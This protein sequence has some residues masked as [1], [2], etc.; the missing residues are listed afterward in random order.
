MLDLWPSKH[1]ESEN[2]KSENFS[3]S[4]MPE[5]WPSEH[6]ESERDLSESESCRVKASSMS[7]IQMAQCHNFCLL[8][9][10]PYVGSFL[11]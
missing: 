3:K 6:D 10:Q 1:D 2:D 7:Y 5:L 11:C 8:L 4:Q 9:L